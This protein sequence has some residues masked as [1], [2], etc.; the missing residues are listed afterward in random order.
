MEREELDT[1]AL[2]VHPGVMN[3]I[4]NYS[5]HVIMW[6]KS[7]LKS[8]KDDNRGKASYF[9]LL[10]SLVKLESDITDSSSMD[11]IFAL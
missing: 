2:K 3:S 4:T 1:A 8:I 10:N 11:I 5:A 6:S 7:N 9:K